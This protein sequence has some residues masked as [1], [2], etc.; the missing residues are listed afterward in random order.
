MCIRDRNYNVSVAKLKELEAQHKVAYD[1]ATEV[2][3][4]MQKLRDYQ[5]EL[6][7]IDRFI[8]TLDTKLKETSVNTREGTDNVNIQVLE[9]AR[10]YRVPVRPKK[11]Q[12][13][14]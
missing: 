9:Y 10:E 1:A 4:G 14:G 13:L 12:V 11:L 5:G 2:A 8:E 7:R 6:S 3:K